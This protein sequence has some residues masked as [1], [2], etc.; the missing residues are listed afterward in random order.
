MKKLIL[1][2]TMLISILI[3]SGCGMKEEKEVDKATQQKNMTKVQNDASEVIGKDYNQ[4]LDIMGKPYITT[5]Y[6]NTKDYKDY[7]SL[8]DKQLLSKLNAQLVY[9]KEGYESSA[10]YLD[11]K[12]NKVVGVKSNEFVG[13]S[14]GFE[15]MP[16][17]A[18]SSNF[19]I[20]F[21]NKQEYIKDKDL[22]LDTLK[23]YV[24]QTEDELHKNSV[25]AEPNAKAYTKDKT[26]FINYYIL[27]NDKGNLE[28]M[29]SV[30]FENNKITDISKMSEM[31]LLRK[32]VS[33]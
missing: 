21:Y 26:K 11:L 4:V 33:L 14:S 30:T 7:K 15:D 17:Y 25:L 32:I 27:S 3:F 12:N 9:P 23:S 5:C 18:K 10:L 19:I 1:I 16:D 31:D 20:D 13:L 28:N 6:I 8:S 29:I 2:S 24:G 22:E